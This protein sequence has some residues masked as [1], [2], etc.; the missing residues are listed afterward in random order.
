MSIVGIDFGA[1]RIGVAVSESGVV[2]TPHSVI[3]NEGDVI[4]KIARDGAG[5]QKICYACFW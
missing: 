2:A 5:R 4:D 3:R 1:R